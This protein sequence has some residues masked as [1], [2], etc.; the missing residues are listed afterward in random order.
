MAQQVK[1]YHCALFQ[2]VQLAAAQAQQQQLA[3][4][5]AVVVA[6]AKSLAPQKP[7]PAPLAAMAP[8]Q[9]LLNVASQLESLNKQF[10]QLGQSNTVNPC[11]SFTPLSIVLEKKN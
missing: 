8:P 3:A 2:A 4:A 10:T 9:P 11:F 7:A 6:A 5:A 1:C